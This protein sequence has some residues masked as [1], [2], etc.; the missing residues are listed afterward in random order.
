MGAGCLRMLIKE[1]LGNVK[2]K[3]TLQQHS[4]STAPH[5]SHQGY[6]AL[7]SSSGGSRRSCS[8]ESGVDAG[9]D[10]MRTGTQVG[11][12]SFQDQCRTLV[13]VEVSLT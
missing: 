9:G 12:F 8:A 3:S 4:A 1:G 13:L 2:Q 6:P 5:G 7:S 11:L 10:V